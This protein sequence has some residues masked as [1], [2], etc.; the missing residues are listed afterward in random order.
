V[1]HH[2]DV[3]DVADQGLSVIALQDRFTAN[4]KPHRGRIVLVRNGYESVD[5]VC[6]VGRELG[7]QI[8][9]GIAFDTINAANAR[10]VGERSVSCNLACHRDDI[11]CD[12]VR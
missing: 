10:N 8:R 6:A 1:R 3:I 12:V 2:S 5:L 11:G 9:T 4:H 7:A